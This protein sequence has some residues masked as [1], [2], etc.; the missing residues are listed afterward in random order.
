MQPLQFIH[1]YQNAD[2]SERSIA[3]THF[4]DLCKL[5]NEN[6][7]VESDPKGEW[8]TFEKALRRQHNPKGGPMFGSV[9][10]LPGSIRRKEKVFEMRSIK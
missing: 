2:L 1:T 3:Q 4:N 10:V 7:P 5:L 6:T 9:V 8:F